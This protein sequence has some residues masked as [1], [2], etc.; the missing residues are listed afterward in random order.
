MFSTIV[1]LNDMANIQRIFCI[2]HRQKNNNDLSLSLFFNLQIFA[3][4][5][6]YYTIIWLYYTFIWQ[7]H[8]NNKRHDYHY[9]NIFMIDELICVWCWR[10]FSFFSCV[11]LLVNVFLFNLKK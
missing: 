10:F 4:Y 11:W 3:G 7:K 9:N 2:T 6:K 8:I 1:C 5:S